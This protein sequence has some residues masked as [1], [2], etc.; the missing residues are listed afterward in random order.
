MQSTMD[1]QKIAAAELDS[2]HDTSVAAVQTHSDHYLK[3]EYLVLT[4]PGFFLKFFIS[5]IVIAG[6]IGWSSCSSVVDRKSY[7]YSPILKFRIDEW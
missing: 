2:S 1:S 6:I 7:P 3:E 4:C 5:T